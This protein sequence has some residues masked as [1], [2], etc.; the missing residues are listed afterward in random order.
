MPKI[1][2]E[3]YEVLKALDDKWRWIARDKN[4][5]LYVFTG[6]PVKKYGPL[7]YWGTEGFLSFELFDEKDLF[8]FIQW[9][10]EE[11]YNIQELIKEYESEEEVKE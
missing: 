5:C 1:N 7:L 9:E 3:E 2:K 8:Q 6:K 11:P 4:R 10:D